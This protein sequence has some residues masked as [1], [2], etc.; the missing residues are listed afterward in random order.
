MKSFILVAAILGGLS[1]SLASAS[2]SLSLDIQ[3]TDQQGH[4][5]GTAKCAI[6]QGT[7]NANLKSTW[8]CAFN[9]G[10][11]QTL[12]TIADY[13]TNDASDGEAQEI[14]YSL[15]AGQD[16]GNFLFK[17]LNMTGATGFAP[18]IITL[19]PTPS[20][21]LPFIMVSANGNSSYYYMNLT[22]GAS[23]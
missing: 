14:D 13:V 11:N 18:L 9:G 7:S 12:V 16:L 17:G 15:M 20:T 4:V 23:K 2:T 22:V 6:D 5:V 10:A 21:E 19:K 3:A 8:T 1:A